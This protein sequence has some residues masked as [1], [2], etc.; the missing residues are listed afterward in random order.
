M[1]CLLRDCQTHLCV[2]EGFDLDE[3]KNRSH[4]GGEYLRHLRFGMLG[5]EVVTHL[6]QSSRLRLIQRRVPER[7]SKQ[8]RSQIG[9]GPDRVY[10]RVAY[11]SQ[12]RT[13]A[14]HDFTDIPATVRQ[15]MKISIGVSIVD[16]EQAL[17]ALRSE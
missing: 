1:L 14:S 17:T 4:I 8:I 9:I 3:S 13:L 2:D 5:Y 7:I 15:R 10:V 12:D 6:A 11:N 16:A